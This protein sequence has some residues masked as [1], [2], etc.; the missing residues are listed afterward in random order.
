VKELVRAGL[1]STERDGQYLFTQ[2][3]PGVLE[4]YTEELMRRVGGD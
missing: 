3:R 2:V 1:V 4:A